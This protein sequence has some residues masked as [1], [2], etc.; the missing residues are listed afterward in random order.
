MK[1]SPN[2]FDAIKNCPKPEDKKALRSFLGLTNYLKASVADY[3]SITY[4]LRS[5]R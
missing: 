2:K 4:S 5:W 3:S 1:P